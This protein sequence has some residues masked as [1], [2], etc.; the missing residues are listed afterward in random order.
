MDSTTINII[1]IILF[2]LLYTQISLFLDCSCSELIS[3]A[4]PVGLGEQNSTTVGR[5]GKVAPVLHEK[6]SNEGVLGDVPID[7]EALGGEERSVSRRLGSQGNSPTYPTARQLQVPQSQS[8]RRET[9][10]PLPGI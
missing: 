6:A 2:F 10:L 3:I 9:S 7:G 5:Y 4:H 8:R 1:I